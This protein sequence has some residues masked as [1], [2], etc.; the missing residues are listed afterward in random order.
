ALVELFTGAECPPC[1]G[2][3]AACDALAA[4]FQH[5]EAI[6]LQYH[7]HIPARDPLANPDAIARSEYYDLEGVPAAFFNGGETISGGSSMWKS[8][9]L[10]REYRRRVEAQLRGKNSA[11]VELNVER[12]ANTLSIVS[13][14]KTVMNPAS[15]PSSASD[16]K[17]EPKLR[18]RLALTEQLVRYAGGNGVRLNHHV[19]RDF[20]GG[21]EGQELVDGRAKVELALELDDVRR[22]LND[23]REKQAVFWALVCPSPI[24]SVELKH[25]TIIAFVQ[26]DTTKQVL[27]AV[28]VRMPED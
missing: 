13:S 17:G 12:A 9:G 20:P 4:A 23:Y 10:Y 16:A 21:L 26:D 6:L 18:L 7:L 8:D 22:D 2:A 1:A 3:D 5:G 27:H 15:S 11:A 24:P 19:V 14:A 28:Q 25:L